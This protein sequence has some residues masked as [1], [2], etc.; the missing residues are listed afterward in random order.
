M[1][2][3]VEKPVTAFKV[4]DR[5]QIVHLPTKNGSEIKIPVMVQEVLRDGYRVDTEFQRGIKVKSRHLDILS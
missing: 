2:T 5:A 1:I 3:D 4:G